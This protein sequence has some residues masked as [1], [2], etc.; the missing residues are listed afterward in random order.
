MTYLKTQLQSNSQ[1]PIKTPK[2]RKIKEYSEPFN[3]KSK[4]KEIVKITGRQKGIQGNINSCYLDTLLMAMFPF[5]SVFDYLLYREG[6]RD[7]IPDYNEVQSILKDKIVK[8]L[9]E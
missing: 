5:T 2:M 6:T 1:Q 8:P 3:V 4:S 9:R 7:D